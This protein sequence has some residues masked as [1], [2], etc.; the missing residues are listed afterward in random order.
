[1]LGA[2]EAVFQWWSSAAAAPCSAA[3]CPRRR[4]SAEEIRMMFEI[5][6]IEDLK[7]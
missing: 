2:A 1:M 7:T 3:R 4:L 5:D 6:D